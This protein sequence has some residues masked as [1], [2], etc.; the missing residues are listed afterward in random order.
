[1]RSVDARKFLVNGEI[2]RI[3]GQ[4]IH[5]VGITSD[6]P[7]MDFSY[8]AMRSPLLLLIATVVGYASIAPE[9]KNKHRDADSTDGGHDSTMYDQAKKKPAA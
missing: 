8:I 3:A 4:K 2:W 5:R 1:M 6:G 9:E 7:A